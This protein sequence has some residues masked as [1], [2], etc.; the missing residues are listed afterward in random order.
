LRTPGRLVSLKQPIFEIVTIG[1]EL[2]I[3]K[4][5]NTNAHWLAKRITNLGG[6][7]S[8]IIVVG[9]DVGNIVSVINDALGRRPDFVITIGGLG[10]TFDDKT[11]E[12]I[13]KAF[14]KPLELN[15][16]AYKLVKE[17]YLGYYETGLLKK[18]ELTPSR[19]KMAK[20]PAGAKPLYNPV[21]TAPGIFLE[22]KGTI[23]I[24]L[25][26][27]PKEMQGIFEDDVAILVKRYTK[28]LFSCV[29]SLRITGIVESEIAPLIDVVMRENPHVYIKS[30]PKAAEPTPL[31]ELHFSATSDSEGLSENRVGKAIESISGKI[32]KKGGAVELLPA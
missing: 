23:L 29:E 1:N 14:G 27:V 10:P 7:V 18:F 21:G 11:L 13:S 8:R 31:I 28:N 4:I 15:K 30:H 26:G 6:S 19:L 22:H 20:L 2:L 12:A 5:L 24:A 32:I 25:P 16:Q 9:D 3:G 17:K